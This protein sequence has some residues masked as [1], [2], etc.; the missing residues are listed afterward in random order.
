MLTSKSTH[1]K[2]KRDLEYANTN[3]KANIST[4]KKGMQT[5]QS[6]WHFSQKES[7]VTLKISTTM[8]TIVSHHIYFSHYNN[9]TDTRDGNIGDEGDGEGSCIK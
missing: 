3:L 4:I 1:Y 7:I 2:T 6:N 5:L 9:R 8:T